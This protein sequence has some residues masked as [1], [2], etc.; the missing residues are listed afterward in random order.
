MQN[1]V[2]HILF[3]GGGTGGHLFPALSIAESLKELD[4]SCMISFIG[5]KNKIEARIV[6]QS[7]FPFYPIW[8]SG[9][10]RRF[11]LKNLLLPIKISVSLLQVYNLL[12]K[13]SPSIIIG[14]GGYV[15]GPVLRVASWLKI[16][17]I[18][19]ES[20]SFP[21][22]TTRIQS[23]RAEKVYLAFEETK[24]YLSKKVNYEVVGNPTRKKFGTISKTA[25]NKY[26]GLN[27]DLKT[28]L[29]FG[30]SL[31]AN[32]I[33][34]SIYSILDLLQKKNYQII[35]QTGAKDAAFYQSTIKLINVKIFQF[36]D[37]MEYAY[38]A[39]DIVVCRAGATTISE[40]TLLGKPAI[41]IP[42]PFAAGNHQFYNAKTLVDKNAAVMIEEKNLDEKLF[43]TI[44]ELLDSENKLKSISTEC[45]KLGKPNVSSIIAKQILQRISEQV[46]E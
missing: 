8:I 35:W 46:N 19:H 23:K 4:S 38:A 28:I 16:P 24:K 45:K 40:L 33:N 37:E 3:T 12:K 7:G 30:G 31:G 17:T 1:K 27:P 20:N 44:T 41:L 6:P 29:V 18:I 15:C 39:S 2:K 10:H 11:T 9:L 36:I 32:K 26:F 22:I 14:T 34:N 42:Y 5:T 21:G 25:G 13:L 43:N